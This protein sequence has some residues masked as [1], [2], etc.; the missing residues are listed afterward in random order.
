MTRVRTT[1]AVMATC[2]VALAAPALAAGP[3]QHHHHHTPTTQ[4]KT[5][6]KTTPTPAPAQPAPAPSTTSTPPAT[7]TP[8][9]PAPTPAPAAKPAVHKP[10]AK[11]K[12]K[13]AAHR[14]VK[15][16]AP[17]AKPPSVAKPKPA[18]APLVKQSSGGLP[19]TIIAVAL[20]ALAAG[21]AA[22]A[23]GTKVIRR[24]RLAGDHGAFAWGATAAAAGH[25]LL[26]WRR[27]KSDEYDTPA[28][29]YAALVPGSDQPK[30]DRRRVYG[31]RLRVALGERGMEIAIVGLGL[32]A[33][34]LLGALVGGM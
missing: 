25:R 9:A 17:A 16:S 26:P 32:A 14:A 2:L 11:H 22:T 28:R 10:A 23:L 24:R 31:D 15:H 30:G 19:V 33:A 21:L 7:S 6:H 34:V 3:P 18:S 5:R 4:P 29:G 8:A 12:P 27:E 20:L 1:A 13:P